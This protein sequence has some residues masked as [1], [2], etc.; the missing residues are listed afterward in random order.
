[1]SRVITPFKPVFLEVAGE[2]NVPWGRWKAMFEDY[3]LAID[4]PDGEEHE[5]RKAAL[6]RAS[7]G[8]E[9]YRIFI[10]IKVRH[11]C[12]WYDHYYYYIQPFW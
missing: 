12:C 3:L 10:Y 7:L 8:V 6:L 2:P 5:A 4:F 1:M 9:G 11:G